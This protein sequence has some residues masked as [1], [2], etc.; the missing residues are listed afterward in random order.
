METK[1]CIKTRRSI[2][3]FTA[4]P[5][6]RENLEKIIELASYAPSWKNTQTSRYIAIFDT[7]LKDQIADEG[8]CGFQHNTE[9][10]HN[11]SALVL[12]TT[13][14]GRSGYERDGSPSTPKTSHW[15]S[16]DAGIAAQTFCLA[17]HE[18]GCGTVILGI[19]DE[20][21]IKELTGVPE[22][23]DI[24]ALIA[25][26]HPAEAPSAPKRKTVEELVTYR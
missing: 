8:V 4:E 7:D 6:T 3:R 10:I 11:A 14:R 22:D 5:V 18:L 13:V 21:K 19:Y 12:L 16:F 17:A 26:G 15:E 20:K 9:I 2:R 25:I 24:S 23:Q 1:T